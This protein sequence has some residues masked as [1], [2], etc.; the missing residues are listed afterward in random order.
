MI[1]VE[2]VGPPGK[3]A[4]KEKLDMS[5]Q[6][7]T[8]LV[9]QAYGHFQSGEIPAVLDL[10]SEDVEWLSPE[11]EGVP[12]ARNW[13]GREQVGQFFQTLSDTQEAR[14]FEPREFVAQGDKVV[15]LGHYAWHV[16]STGREWESDFAHVFTV[17]DGSVTKFQ[18]YTNTAAYA[19]AFR[20]G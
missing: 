9:Q 10:L 20:E 11:L 15:A 7:N 2:R 6:E 4:G 1:V 19:D 8:T 3:R 12:L 18:E 17:H 13:H 16:K 5:E 14:Q